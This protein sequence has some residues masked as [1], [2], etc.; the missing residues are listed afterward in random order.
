MNHHPKNGVI[1]GKDTDTALLNADKNSK[2][3]KMNHKSIENQINHFITSWKKI[4]IYPTKTFIVKIIPKN[5]FQITTQIILDT[6]HFIIQT[7]EDDHQTKRNNQYRNNYS[8]SNSGQSELSFDTSSHS[9]SKNRHYSNDRS[10]NSTYKR[11]EIIPTIGT[12]TIQMIE[13]KNIKTI[14]HVIILTTDHTIKDHV[15]TTIKM[16]HAIIHTIEIQIITIDK[17]TTLNHHIGTTHVIQTLNKN[18]E[19]LHQNIKNK[20]IKYKQ[21]KKFNPTLLLLIIQKA[22]NCN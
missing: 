8:R 12:E 17:E 7:A 21:L 11:I 2:T 1:I 3:T 19:V 10:R 15:I 16:N 13:I 18:I 6:N 20:W 5:H 9:H 22:Q 14:D 4:K